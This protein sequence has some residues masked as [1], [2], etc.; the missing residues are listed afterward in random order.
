MSVEWACNPKFQYDG[1]YTPDDFKSRCMALF[2]EN[3]DEVLRYILSVYIGWASGLSFRDQI[4]WVFEPSG[5]VVPAVRRGRYYCFPNGEYSLAPEGKIGSMV[6][7]GV[8][9]NEEERVEAYQLRYDVFVDEQKVPADMELDEFDPEA[10]HAVAIEN[11]RVIGTGR[12]VVEGNVG[13]IGRMAVEKEKRGQGIGN[14]LMEVLEQKAVDLGLSEIYLHAQ[15]YAKDFYAKRG[16]QPR[17]EEFDEAGI[18]HI[19]MFRKL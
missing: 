10:V 18:A 2:K 9:K 15:V 6:E 11:G 16:Y 19:E 14:G 5:S 1:V 3:D 12:L 7:Y 4:V 13:R 17:G 8:L